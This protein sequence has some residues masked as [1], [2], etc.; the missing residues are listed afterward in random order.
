[1]IHED[2]FDYTLK[3]VKAICLDNFEFNVKGCDKC[4]LRTKNGNCLFEVKPLFWKDPKKIFR[5][6]NKNET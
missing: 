4:P 2:V 5:K 6:E 3:E 1:M